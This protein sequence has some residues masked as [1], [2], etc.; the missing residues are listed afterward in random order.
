LD[1]QDFQY[2]KMGHEG[3]A[4]DPSVMISLLQKFFP[5]QYK[6]VLY[7]Q[8]CTYTLTEPNLEPV[9]ERKG[10]KGIFAFGLT[11]GFKYM[12]YHGKRLYYMI[13]KNEEESTKYK[14]P[15]PLASK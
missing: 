12:P 15:K 10:D 7:A 14:Y 8:P 11:A 6:Q 5:D 1:G 9:F 3:G 2:F 4:K 13:T